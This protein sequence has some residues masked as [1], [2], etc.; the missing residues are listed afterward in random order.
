MTK[1]SRKILIFFLLSF[2]LSCSSSK[3]VTEETSTGD[4]VYVFDDVGVYDDQA[5]TNVDT[6]NVVV[7]EETTD[8]N[9]KEFIVQ[10]GAFTTR[11]RAERFVTVNQNKINYPMQI[12]YSERV[13]LYVVQ[14]PPFSTRREAEKVRD[15]LWS[16]DIFRDA[17]I[18]TR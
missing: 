2:L 7:N 16:T 15:N 8:G 17:F 9:Y 4:E 18:I 13:N 14:L 11:A 10:V 12:S 5:Q 1:I 6:S 3:K